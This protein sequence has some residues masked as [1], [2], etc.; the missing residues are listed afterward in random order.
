MKT[1]KIRKFYSW[2]VFMTQCRYYT[3]KQKELPYEMIFMGPDAERIS[4][5]VDDEV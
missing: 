3:K 2:N 5:E 1:K 4:K